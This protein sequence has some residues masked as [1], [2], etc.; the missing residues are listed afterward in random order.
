[1]EGMKEFVVMMQNGLHFGGIGIT[2]GHGRRFLSD[3]VSKVVVDGKEHSVLAFHGAV[4]AGWVVLASE[5]GEVK[6]GGAEREK[7]D[8]SVT[9]ADG[10]GKRVNMVTVVHEDNEIK[11]KKLKPA[12]GKPRT[13]EEEILDESEGLV[14]SKVKIPSQFK[15]VKING[16]D[17]KIIEDL[18]KRT[19]V[20]NVVVPGF[21]PRAKK[22]NSAE[23]PR[24][25]VVS[26][27]D[28][29][30]SD[31]LGDSE[32]AGGFVDRNT[33]TVEGVKLADRNTATKEAPEPLSE[34]EIRKLKFEVISVIYKD[35]GY[36]PT[37]PWRSRA[38]V[39]ISNY[40]KNKDL[41]LLAMMVSIE[42]TSVRKEVE[43]GCKPL[44]E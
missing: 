29:E 41:K 24:P 42:T 14:V 16:E 38:K 39:I 26:S 8:R 34:T 37:D 6:P 43:K 30:L 31:V 44:E 20:K 23:R 2:L 3:G 10:S 27:D 13:E 28:R 11:T 35:L 7:V 17:Q 5:V 4:K 36:N 15:T 25:N 21:E 12:N 22:A 32:V 18:E 1:M 33:G 9:K 19:P 40:K